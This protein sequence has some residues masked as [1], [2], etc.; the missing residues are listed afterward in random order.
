MAQVYKLN[1]RSLA[2]RETGVLARIRQSWADYRKFRQTYD[3][4]NA[5]GDRDLADLGLVRLDIP[6]VAREA[7]YGK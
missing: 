2:G 6:F 1:S 3:E 5:L 4:L 7:V